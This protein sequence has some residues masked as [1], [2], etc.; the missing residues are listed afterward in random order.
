MNRPSRAPYTSSKMMATNVGAG[1]YIYPNA[2]TDLPDANSQ[3]VVK[4]MPHR[5]K[6]PCP[7]KYLAKASSRLYNRLG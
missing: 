5:Q 2:R 6:R 4:W 1:L 7:I 3:N